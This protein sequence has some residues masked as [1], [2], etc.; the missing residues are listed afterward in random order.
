V[1]LQIRNI[2]VVA[3]V[4]GMSGIVGAQRPTPDEP[5]Q[6]PVRRVVLYKSGV[7]FFE[8]LG[9]VTGSRDIAIQFTSGQLDDA[10]KSLTALDLDR[11]TV[12]AIS[13]NSVAPLE[14]QLAALRLP[15][16][17]NPNAL[18][19]Y[20]ALRGTRVD[21]RSRG[22]ITT[23]RIL[24]VERR[25]RR[26]DNG[27]TEPIDVI[28]VVGDDGAVRSVTVDQ[29]VT[30]RIDERDVRGDLG[31]YLSVIASGRGQDVRRMVISTS[32][33]GTR[34]LL[35]SYIS[36]VPI[37]KSTYRLV[38]PDSATEK[39][40]LQG[41]A[42]VD[43]TVGEDW[44]NVEL[45]L[46]AGAP[47][48][49]IQQ[50]SQPYYTR[51][52]VVPLPDAVQRTPQTH[53]S[54]L[55]IAPESKTQE[56]IT[57]TGNSPMADMSLRRDGGGRGG[58][59]V[60]GVV[61]GLPQAPA[62]PPS[63]AAADA[64][65]Q[66]R[67]A[68]TVAMATAQDLGD[69]F[70]YKLKQPVTIRKNQSALVPILNS[71]VDAERVSVWRG[72]PGN[73]RPLRAVWLTNATGL[74]LDG[75][76]LSVIEANAFAGEGLVQPLKPGEKRLVSY[77]TDLAVMVDSRLD[78]S[79][80][81]F[82]R[83]TARDGVMIAQQEDRN[84]WVYRVRNEDSTART[85]IVEHPVRQGWTLAASPAPTETTT[86]A[87]RFRVAVA[88]KGE[89]TLTVNERHVIDSRYSLDQVDERLIT[90]ITQ[91]GILPEALR[92]ALQPVL[93]KRAELAAADREL[94][95]VNAQVTSIGQ[96]QQ[97]VRQNMQVL[98]GSSEE[99]ALVK[100]YTTELNQQEDRLA[101]LRKQLADTTARRDMRRTELSQLI[102]RLTFALDAPAAAA[103]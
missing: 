49:F 16:G 85:I 48:S 44:T 64:L 53:E 51:R 59:V 41:W 103:P 92:Q 36:E 47:Q 40:L 21:I 30:V 74:T 61:G 1:R 24:S 29:D 5:T 99:K 23:G 54:T 102:Q 50:I 8:H 38:L 69:L 55:Q 19:L 15:L 14:Q 42:I 12:S 100:R 31:R 65:R 22:M 71:P 80:G 56:T 57:V 83:V 93:D 60:G 28:T 9:N 52:S 17:N 75:G 27:N 98:K 97:R 87:A 82:T 81:R 73:G 4:L 39:P 88:A 62:A 86:T 26:R 67:M 13:Y 76:S 68:E 90:T 58:G 63:L 72:T 84:Q 34:R 78:Q 94:N 2:I 70:E 66:Q 3:A 45:S 89:A 77:G 33:A 101:T 43:N 96:D 79:S 10:L 35:V 6:L 20:E 18:G 25:D 91:R 11:G 32:G 37:W 7:G 46:V 95:D